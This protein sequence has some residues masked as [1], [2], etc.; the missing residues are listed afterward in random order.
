MSGHAVAVSGKGAT[1]RCL[2]RGDEIKVNVNNEGSPNNF[3]AALY[4]EAQ[5]F[6]GL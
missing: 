4:C 3:H 1:R 5:T 2:A 6:Q